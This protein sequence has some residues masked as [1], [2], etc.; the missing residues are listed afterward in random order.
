MVACLPLEGFLEGDFQIV[1]QVGAAGGGVAAAAAAGELAEHLV[2]NVGEARG[3]VEA[4]VGRTSA[5]ALEGGMTE[6]V[7]G[8]ALLLVLEDVVG[9]VDLFELVLAGR[10]AR[11][12]VRMILHSELAVGL[13]EGLGI[14]IAADPEQFVKILLTC[15]VADRCT[16]GVRRYGLSRRSSR[17]VRH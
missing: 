4:V 11:I 16:P 13:L 14:G 8:R 7:V 12:A 9:F 17:V 6:A 2:E 3:E 15:H 5:A 1:A 10:V